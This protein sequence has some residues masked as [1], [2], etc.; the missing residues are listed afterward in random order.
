VSIIPVNYGQATVNFTGENL[1]H[2][3]AVVFGFDNPEDASP[4]EAAGLVW[5]AFAEFVPD[6]CTS[7][8]A[9]ASVDVK[10]GPNETG[11]LGSYSAAAVPGA[12]GG[13]SLGPQCSILLEKRTGTGGRRGR[14][15]MYVPG[16]YDGWVDDKGAYVSGVQAQIDGFADT[17]LDSLTTA[18]V[19]MVVL[20]SPSY[21]WTITDGQPRRV[22][23][24][25]G[26]APAPYLVTSLVC[27]PLIATQRRRLR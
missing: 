7:D 15:R 12:V 13:S 6:C 2:G 27:D 9:L 4:N 22:Y 14:G 21:T 19:P 18:A 10:L 3:G 25:P 8:V 23:G 17:L 11:G 24:D 20:H 26:L 5:A 1:P 16:V